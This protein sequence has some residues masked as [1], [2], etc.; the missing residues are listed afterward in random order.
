MR[1]LRTEAPNRAVNEKFHGG[2]RFAHDL[3]GLLRAAVLPEPERHGEPLL[4]GQ[5]GNQPPEVFH[6]EVADGGGL[7][8]GGPVRQSIRE[9]ATRRLVAKVI[10]H[11]VAGDPVEPAGEGAAAGLVSADVLQ[12]LHENLGRYVFGRRR[13]T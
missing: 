2:L 12:C 1:R 9:F 5:P 7:D 8:R 10:G 6:L 13:V 11:G 3:G 4:G